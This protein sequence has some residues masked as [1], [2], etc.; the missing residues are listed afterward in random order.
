MTTAT[1]ELKRLVERATPGEWKADLDGSIK[2]RHDD[3]AWLTLCPSMSSFGGYDAWP[4]TKANAGLIALTPTLAAEVIASRTTIEALQDRVK[5][6]EAEI[7]GPH[8]YKHQIATL[9]RCALEKSIAVGR[10]E[11]AE[12]K[13]AEI[14]ELIKPFCA[15][16]FNDNGDVTI[17]MH[18]LRSA[19]WLNASRIAALA[20]V[21]S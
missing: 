13:L 11:A 16:V 14:A 18:S 9:H 2:I 1:E 12:R 17:S 5:T 15:C 21:T 19:E 3:L 20:K 10:A 6:L 4:E 8:G 7:D